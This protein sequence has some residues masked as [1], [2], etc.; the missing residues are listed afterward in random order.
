MT[1]QANHDLPLPSGWSR[2]P[3]RP[4]ASSVARWKDEVG[5]RVYLYASGRVAVE[6]TMALDELLVV[7]RHAED[8]HTRRTGRAAEARF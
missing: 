8:E 7:L 5:H 1:D 4:H 2:G 3:D 6:G